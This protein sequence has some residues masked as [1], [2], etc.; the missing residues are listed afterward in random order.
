[1]MEKVLSSVPTYEGV[2]FSWD[3]L[4]GF[5][6]ASE[7]HTPPG[8]AFFQRVWSD[9]GDVGFFVKSHRTGRCVLFTLEDVERDESDIT[10]WNFVE[11]N[12]DRSVREPV[13]IKVFND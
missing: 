1:M 10:S 13:R 11:C 2:K 6:E 5:C 7:L 9:A 8:Q 12:V 4:L 3:K